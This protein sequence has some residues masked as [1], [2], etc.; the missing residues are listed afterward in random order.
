MK[1]IAYFFILTAILIFF[2]GCSL[3]NKTGSYSDFI[4]RRH[5]VKKSQE[6]SGKNESSFYIY[7]VFPDSAPTEGKIKIRVYGSGFQR[8]AK[9]F[10]SQPEFYLETIY[11]NPGLL[12]VWLPP[13]YAGR[14]II[15]VINPDGR[16]TRWSKLFKYL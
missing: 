4:N 5:F 10:L 8:G 9:V 1:K 13:H 14:F 11:L 2:S 6:K 12:E 15:G 7:N 3:P 16:I